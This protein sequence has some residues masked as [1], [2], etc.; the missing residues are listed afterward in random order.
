MKTHFRRVWEKWCE[1]WFGYDNPLGLALLRIQLGL[2]MLW[3]YLQRQFFGLGDF[4]SSAMIPREWAIR[5]LPQDMRP[6][7]AWFFWPDGWSPVVHGIFLVLLVLIVLGVRV[8]WFAG[9]AWVIHLGFIQRNYSVQF[10]ADVISSVVLFYL[11]WTRSDERL[12]L[13]DC[14]RRGSNPRVRGP[15]VVSS[16][17][18]RLLQVQLATIYVYTGLEKLRG[19]SW[20][21]GTALWTVLGN[22]QMVAFD[23]GF[24]RQVPL[25]ISLITFATMLFEIYWA[26]AVMSS[27]VRPWWLWAG[28]AFHCGIGMLMGLWTF[29][30]IMLAVYWLFVSEQDI[31]AVWNRVYRLF[32][33]EKAR[34]DG[35]RGV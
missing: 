30:L 12:S 21:D 20:W 7:F 33:N 4:G 17:F 1:F 6:P 34:A 15:D 25:L 2:V 8:R 24:L 32:Q 13:L 35:A 10:G 9:L 23:V 29:S 18:A 31:L 3:M 22:P 27:K 14:W 5:A 28:V 11:A 19:W 16:V 26:P